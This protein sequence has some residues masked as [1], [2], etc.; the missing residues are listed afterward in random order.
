MREEKLKKKSVLIA[1]TITTL[2]LI[3]LTE[4]DNKTELVLD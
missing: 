3:I 2:C 4:A 1:Q